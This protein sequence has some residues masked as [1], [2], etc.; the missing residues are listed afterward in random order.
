[1]TS[2]SSFS[3][4]PSGPGTTSASPLCELPS[5]MMIQPHLSAVAFLLGGDFNLRRVRHLLV[6]LSVKGILCQRILC[7]G[8]GFLRNKPTDL[9]LDLSLSQLRGGKH[10]SSPT[11]GRGWKP[12]P[13]SAPHV[14]VATA[15]GGQNCSH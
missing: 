15:G 5:F 10:S 12:G 8:E 4:S 2:T 1:M 9:P 11:V 6:L 7:C 14:A 13:C 3:S